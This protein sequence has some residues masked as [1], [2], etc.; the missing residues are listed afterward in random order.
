M[1]SEYKKTIPIPVPKRTAEPII[2]IV[3]TIKNKSIMVA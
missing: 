1:G 3:F 2:W